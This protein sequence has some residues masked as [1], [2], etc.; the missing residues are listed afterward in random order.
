MQDPRE[1]FDVV[2]EQDR[3]NGQAAR[4]EVH[5]R[6]LRHR[7]VHIFL[8]N[9]AGKLFIQKRSTSKDT[10][11]GCYDSSASGHLESGEDYDAC[12]LRELREELG[13]ELPALSLRKH[14]KIEACEETGWEFLWIYAVR[15][16]FKINLNP[17]EIESGAFIALDEVERLIQREPARCAPGFVW[18]FRGLQQRGLLPYTNIAKESSD[19]DG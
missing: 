17:T 6:G 14:F 9:T 2:D 3:V 16:D 5:A 12:A 13:I 1:L 8:F 11:P 15:G 10:Y 19:A 18:V 7:A 4:A